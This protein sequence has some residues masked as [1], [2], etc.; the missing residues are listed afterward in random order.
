MNRRSFIQRSFAAAATLSSID[1]KPAKAGVKNWAWIPTNTRPTLDQWKSRFEKLRAAGIQAI[2]PEVYAGREAFFASTHLPVKQDWLGMLLPLAKA[3][4]LEVHAWMWAMPCMIPDMVKAHPDWYNVNAKGES[5]ADKPAYVPYYKFLDP[6]RPEAREWVQATVKELASIPELT[7]IHL[8]YIRHPDAILPSGLW[9]KYNIVQDHVFPE[10][11]YGYTEYERGEFKKRYGADPMQKMDAKLD[12]KWF[13][14]RLEMVTGLVNGYLVPAARAGKKQIT[15]AVF[16]GPSL[17]RLN[18]RQDWG[19]WKLDAFLPMLY[20]SFYQE[21]PQWVGKMTAEGV[22]AARKPLYSGL[23]LGGMKDTEFAETIT[24]ALRAGAG[25]VSI[26]AENG[27][28]D[29][30]LQVL[31]SASEKARA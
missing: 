10:Y 13:Q 1:A 18:V 27:L 21:T 24:Q 2:L 22:H 29:E 5:A 9:K 30:R 8:D 28:T 11:D 3:A 15:A 16:P 4:G 7:G 25:G 17:A 23:F 14:F 19:R 26:F 20:H 12:G 6:G 31:K